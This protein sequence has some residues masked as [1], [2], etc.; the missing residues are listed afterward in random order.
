MAAFGRKGLMEEAIQLLKRG[1]E[2]VLATL[3]GDQP[4]NSAVGYLY[5]APD[6]D[7]RFGKAIVLMS[8]LARHT[9]NVRRHAET[10]LMVIDAGKVAVYE[11]K[12]VTAQGA[13]VEIKDKTR[14]ENYKKDYLK[15]YP[16]S[17]IFFTLP[18]FH[19]FEMAIEELYY[20]GGFG[21]IQSYK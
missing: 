9:K 17:Q 11:K 21:K 15:L 10:S 4:F 13:L 12:R 8:E 6:S 2:A 18:D 5:E 1:R 14:F 16:N 7:H 20:I 3:E 19:F